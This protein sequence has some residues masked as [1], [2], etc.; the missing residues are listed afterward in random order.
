MT[1]FTSGL[2]SVHPFSISGK[3]A[4]FPNRWFTSHQIFGGC[5]DIVITLAHYLN[6]F[7]L[8]K[9]SNA[10]FAYKLEATIY[11]AV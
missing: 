8:R 5:N 7:W 6:C 11:T 4:F 10:S 1:Y 2:P 9:V 3:K